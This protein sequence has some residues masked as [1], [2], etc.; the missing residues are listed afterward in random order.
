MDLIKEFERG[1][2][3]PQ[4]VKVV[5]K[6]KTKIIYKGFSITKHEDGIYI[7]SDCR[8][9]TFYSDINPNDL[10]II[11]SNGFKKGC[12]IIQMNG[13]ELRVTKIKRNIAKIHNQKSTL[14]KSNPS[15]PTLKTLENNMAKLVD[16]LF[17]YKSRLK[18]LKDKLNYE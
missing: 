17:F 6:S 15:S 5:F 8:K 11:E 7:L 2:N 3:D 16:E 18:Q 13:D 10:Q 12:D 1:L 4:F 9:S 14:A